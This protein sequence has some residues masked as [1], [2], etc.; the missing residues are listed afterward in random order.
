M[1]IT[2]AEAALGAKVKV[3]DL[4]GSS[5]TLK[6]PP[7]TPNGK[8]FRV[9]GRGVKQGSRQGDLLVT[10]VIDVPDNLTDAQRAA[11]EAL[12]EATIASPRDHLYAVATA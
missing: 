5:V 7:G 6:I 4:E 3:P 12:A 2:F 9:K 1:P 8:T 10:I 11:I